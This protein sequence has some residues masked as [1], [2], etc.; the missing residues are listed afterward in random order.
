MVGHAARLARG[1]SAFAA[2]AAH[3]ADADAAAALGVSELPDDAADTACGSR[4]Q[5][6]QHRLCD[7]YRASVTQLMQVWLSAKIRALQCLQADDA[8]HIVSATF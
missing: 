3:A 2:D 4:P 7:A 5:G 1:M 8:Q 6:G